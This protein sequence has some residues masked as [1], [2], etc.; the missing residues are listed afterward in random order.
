MGWTL[1]GYQVL[2]KICQEAVRFSRTMFLRSRP[3]TGQIKGANRKIGVHCAELAR[4]QENPP[5]TRPERTDRWNMPMTK[6]LAKLASSLALAALGT[7]CFGAEGTIYPAAY[8]TIAARLRPPEADQPLPVRAM[9][10]HCIWQN[11]GATTLW[12]EK[13][14][15][16]YVDYLAAQKATMVSVYLWPIDKYGKTH[17]R[18]SRDPATDNPATRARVAMYQ[19]LAEYVHSKG[20]EFWLG[21]SIN[22][23]SP[24][25]A[26]RHKEWLAAGGADLGGEGCLL[27]PCIPEARKAL[28]DLTR[29]QV[30][31]Y[32]KCD[33]FFMGGIDLGGCQDERCKPWWKTTCLLFGEHYQVIKRLAPK[34]KVAFCVWG[35]NKDEA[36]QMIPLMPKEAVFQV[37]SRNAEVMPDAVK[38]GL[39]TWM[40][41]ELDMESQ[42][43]FLCPLHQRIKAAVDRVRAAGGKGVMGFSITPP[44]RVEN[45]VTMLVCARNARLGADQALASALDAIYGPELASKLLPVYQ[46]L[47]Q[48]WLASGQAFVPMGNNQVN[49]RAAFYGLRD[50]RKEWASLEPQLGKFPL[51]R[52][53]LDHIARA[54][55]YREVKPEELKASEVFLG[56]ETS[57]VNVVVAGF[58]NAELKPFADKTGAAYT[59]RVV[60]ESNTV[61]LLRHCKPSY[62]NVVI[63]D[64]DKFPATITVMVNGKQ[65]GQYQRGSR[66]CEGWVVFSFPVPSDVLNASGVQDVSI[67]KVGFP[68][69]VA[70]LGLS[71]Q[72]LSGLPKS[73]ART[74]KTK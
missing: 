32:S 45:E 63:W 36:R 18:F 61:F 60:G 9:Y 22:A 46:Q 67:S 1:N 19:K 49:P 29:E 73:P 41:L 34:A 24:S 3:H 54:N 69:G 33:G 17:L 64:A 11:E 39:E 68:F 14:W 57:E 13:Q 42:M 10:V 12:G 71:D 20:M 38:A 4:V 44:L 15:R 27:C 52:K 31:L 28:L 5:G 7:F 62:L 2:L 25:F 51:L 16:E 59:H 43:D 55:A 37:D 48:I 35:Y 70:Y 53:T 58:A 47:S 72:P 8:P 66:P 23:I 65:V 74:R 40:F 56:N 30:E 6:L 26:A 21:W 50:L